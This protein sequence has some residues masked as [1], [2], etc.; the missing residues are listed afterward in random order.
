MPNIHASKEYETAYDLMDIMVENSQRPGEDNQAFVESVSSYLSDKGFY[1]KTVDDPEIEG[2]TLLVAEVGDPEGEQMLATISHA[3]VVGVEG[4]DWH[5]SP[6]EL[7]EK[8]DTWFGRGVC[9]TH[10]SG[11]A[12]LLAAS[13][14]QVRRVLEKAHKRASVVFTYDEEA[15]S[16]ELSMRGARLAAG[17]LGPEAAITSE[18]FVAGEPTEIDGSIVPMRGHKGRWLGHFTVDVA[19]SGHVSEIVQN[20]FMSGAS[21][22]HEIGGYARYLTYGSDT[23]EDAQIYRPPHSTVQVSAAVVKSGDFSTTPSKAQFTVDMRTLPDVHDL[24]VKE[25]TDLIKRGSWDSDVAVLLDVVKDAKGSLTPADSPIVV[26]AE[27]ATG[28]SARGFN[29]GDEGRIMRLQA[30]KEGVTLGPGKLQ[31]AH[32]PNEQIAIRS[33]FR[34]ADIYSKLFRNSVQLGS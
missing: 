13:R 12:M 14:P 19:R 11:V 1:L 29:G 25:I 10:G 27:Q 34:A 3:D 26:A 5:H 6:W 16:P 28:R 17:L 24:R 4:Q 31:Y 20:A 8:D 30:H 2:R 18:Y 15:I 21:I 7:H 32:M 33:I 23:D 22:V 9:D